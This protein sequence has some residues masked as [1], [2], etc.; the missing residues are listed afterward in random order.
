MKKV[1]LSATTLFTLILLA[2]ATPGLADAPLTLSKTA[3]SP[4]GVWQ[5]WATAVA[6]NVKISAVTVNGGR[7]RPGSLRPPK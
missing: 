5:L 1:P 3:I 2:Q 7:C 6:D 4:G